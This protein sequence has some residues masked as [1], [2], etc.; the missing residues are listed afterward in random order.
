MDQ[1]LRC[2]GREQRRV[3]R[4]AEESTGRGGVVVRDGAVH[5]V[6]QVLHHAEEVA[7]GERG[8]DAAKVGPAG[9][10]GQAEAT[11]AEAK[12]FAEAEGEAERCGIETVPP[13][14]RLLPTCDSRP[15]EGNEN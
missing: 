3:A 6:V 2:V 14:E 7:G 11:T 12:A 5:H 4:Q 8:V 13:T 1:E 9:A 15:E 10:H